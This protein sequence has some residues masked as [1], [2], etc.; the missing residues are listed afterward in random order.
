MGGWIK[1]CQKSSSVGSISTSII[2]VKVQRSFCFVL[3]LNKGGTPAVEKSLKQSLEPSRAQ[4][5]NAIYFYYFLLFSYVGLK[6]IE[7]KKNRLGR[8]VSFMRPGFQ[9]CVEQRP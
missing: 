8:G 3:S 4:F 5:A 6:R 1:S 7:K 2:A 9:H